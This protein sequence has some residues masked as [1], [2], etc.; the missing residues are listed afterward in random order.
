MVFDDATDDRR[1]SARMRR[2]I[3]R[4]LRGCRDLLLGPGE[5]SIIDTLIRT[6]QRSGTFFS[7]ID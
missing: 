4:A 1:R 3:R 6:D 7:A 5:A 2:M